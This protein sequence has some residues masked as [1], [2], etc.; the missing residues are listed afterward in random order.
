MCE[1]CMTE[2]LD[3]GEVVPGIWIIQ[4]V[5]DGNKMKAGD[6]G[7]VYCNDPFVIWSK[8][9]YPDPDPLDELHDSDGWAIW[10]KDA[11]DFRDKLLLP[12]ETGQL[13]VGSCVSAGWDKKEH[14]DMA[15]WLYDRMGKFLEEPKP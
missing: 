6:Y 5:K 3:V 7:L 8:R 1:Q 15:Y 14:G 11:S 2:C 13:L 4:A 12:P 9:P 10:Y